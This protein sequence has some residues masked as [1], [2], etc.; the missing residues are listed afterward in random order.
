MTPAAGCRRPAAPGRGAGDRRGRHGGAV[1]AEERQGR[2]RDRPDADEQARRRRAHRDR[3]RPVLAPRYAEAEQR[4][5]LDG[6]HGHPAHAG[7]PVGLRHP[8]PD[9]G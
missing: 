3:P 2:P 5:V 4:G 7:V 1:G 6:Q 8:H 9:Q